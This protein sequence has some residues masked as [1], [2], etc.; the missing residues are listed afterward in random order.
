MNMG[1]FDL[2][3]IRKAHVHDRHKLVRVLKYNYFLLHLIRLINGSRWYKVTIWNISLKRRLHCHSI[4]I[5][6]LLP[7]SMAETTS[8]T[9]SSSATRMVTMTASTMTPERSVVSS[10]SMMPSSAS[11]STSPSTASSWTK[12][13]LFC[14][15][16]HHIEHRRNP[17]LHCIAINILS[18]HPH[19]LHKK[20]DLWHSMRQ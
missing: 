6:R 16:F 4:S 19:H 3:Q 2:S 8:S 17:L 20:H 18:V 9:A 7:R 10:W 13:S 5:L 1:F 11:S 12:M 15:L 14:I